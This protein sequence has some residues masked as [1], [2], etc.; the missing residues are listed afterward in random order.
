MDECTCS[1]SPQRK[2]Q[3]RSSHPGG[4]FRHRLLAPTPESITQPGLEWG[5]RSHISHKLLGDAATSGDPTLR[6]TD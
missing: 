2:I 6:T 3:N 1:I 4:A 5:L